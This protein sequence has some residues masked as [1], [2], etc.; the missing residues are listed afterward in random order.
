M[1]NNGNLVDASHHFKNKNQLLF[2]FRLFQPQ[3]SAMKLNKG[4][5]EERYFRT[6]GINYQIVIQIVRGDYFPNISSVVLSN[7]LNTRNFHTISSP[8]LFWLEVKPKIHSFIKTSLYTLNIT[9]WRFYLE[10]L[11]RTLSNVVQVYEKSKRKWWHR[12]SWTTPSRCV[13]VCGWEHKLV[14]R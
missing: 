8:S 13:R 3:N 9:R 2:I 5:R 7:T 11:L 4:A 1:H 14:V 6:C 10:T 12:V